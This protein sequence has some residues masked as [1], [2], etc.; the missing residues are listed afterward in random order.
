[1]S[2]ADSK[3][4]GVLKKHFPVAAIGASAGGL[5]AMSQL[6]Y[7]LPKNTGIAYIYIQHLDPSHES[8]LVTILRRET[9]MPVVEATDNVKI[10]PDHLYVMPPNKEL[11]LVDGVISVSDRPSR[12]YSSMPINRF[13]ISLADRY[14]EAAIGI[15]LSGTAS[16]GT[17]GLKAIK[18][19]GGITFA[20]DVSAKFHSMPDNAVTDGFVDLILSPKEIA[21]R[22][23][24]IGDQKD[25][26][27][28]AINNLH[29]RSDTDVD[30][31]FLSILQI[32]RKSIDVD[33]SQ[34]KMTTI[35]RRILRRMLIY[36]LETVK[37]Y[38]QYLKQH[39]GEVNTLY[40]DLL[41]NVTSFFRD[42]E[43]SQFLQKTIIPKIIKSKTVNDPIRI[44]VAACSTGQEVYSLAML[45]VEELGEESANTPV[46]IFATDLSEQVINKARI[47]L[48]S[49]DEV[50]D[51]PPKRLHRFFNKTDGHYRVVKSI[52]DL[53]IFA[54]H[55]IAKDPPFSRLDLVSCCNLLIYLD[56]N[57]QRKVI[58][59]FHYAL[60][61]NGYLVLGKSETIGQSDSLFSQVDKKF[62]VYSKKADVASNGMFEMNFRHPDGNKLTTQKIAKAPRGKMDE[63]DLER[64]ADNLLLKKYTPAS[65]IVNNE[66]DIVQFKGSTGLYLEA[67]PGRASLNLMKM[68]RPG[69][70]FELRNIVHKAKK[71]G[72]PAK[73]T[74]LNIN[75]GDKIHPTSIEAIPLKTDT[76]EQYYLVVFEEMKLL[77]GKDYG[78]V[79]DKRVKQLEGE[80]ASLR[81]DMRSIV[82]SQEAANEELQ[83]ANEEIVS[84]NEELQSINEELETSKE[85][86]ESSNEE[87]TT[88]NQ[89]LQVRNEELVEAHEYS[90]A[91]YDTIREAVL[92]LD[93]SLKIKT[94]NNTFFKT[95][96]LT[97][98]ETI[99]VLFNELANKQGDLAPLKKLLQEVIKNDTHF[100][101]YEIK[102][103]FPGSGEKVL[104]L[105]AK[106]VNQKMHGNELVLLAIEDIT[107]MR[108]AQGVLKQQESW[109]KNMAD[110]APVAIW[111]T[112]L[113]KKLNFMNETGLKLRGI[114]LTEAIGKEWEVGAHPEDLETSK[115]IFHDSFDK[116]QPFEI[117]YRLQKYDGNYHPMINKGKPHYDETGE[118]TGY[119][120]TCIELS[121]PL[122]PP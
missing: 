21:L 98:S 51:I 68:A 34:Y 121:G 54:T 45:I 57:L 65:V 78:T 99:G 28:S 49:A 59:T 20:Q 38:L 1:M 91:V 24:Q 87:L 63:V 30:E 16:D 11:S 106:K 67:M 117:S 46:Q 77:P 82:E 22:L 23:S 71:T 31:N 43:S 94:A 18:M 103:F 3:T 25:I 83:S 41:I 19:E 112:G 47:G 81:E 107:S 119:V 102:N 85:E 50:S 93:K 62:R 40:Q 111:V 58:S 14:K 86:I 80:M 4:D 53:C 96:K 115:K 122:S 92:I 110:N 90:Q 114:T 100:E 70:G 37:D 52:R 108:Q 6:L 95:F 13:F 60:N 72:E 75:V 44:W 29:L 39:A 36:K 12:P 69:L 32:V 79:K 17:L 66:L 27:Y 104:L 55:N 48:Y 84:S 64:S 101:D 88:I 9:K 120:G 73:K 109:F 89:E 74:G 116:M 105:N 26:Y 2:P 118:F 76:E 113:D 8:N 7:H 56:T 5:E 42:N 15:V 33:F 97:E 35:K 10:E 61:K